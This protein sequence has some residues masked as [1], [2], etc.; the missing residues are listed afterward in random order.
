MES[1]AQKTQKSDLVQVRNLVKHFAIEN[2][3]DVVQAVD[4]VSFDV[5]R[6]EI[7]GLL[8]PNG[9]GKSTAIKIMLGLLHK[10]FGRCTVF[11]KAPTDVAAK[12]R[13][14][15]FGI[16]RIACNEVDPLAFRLAATSAE[17]APDFQFQIDR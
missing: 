16:E 5:F 9:S 10:S 1:A 15:P 2:S 4:D 11:G 17:H 7:F 6:G 14:G 12:R 8:G 3:D 13:I